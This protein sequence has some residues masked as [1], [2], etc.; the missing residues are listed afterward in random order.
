VA[1][2]TSTKLVIFPKESAIVVVA[3]VP[4]ADVDK[5]AAC[6]PPLV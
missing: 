1:S 5:E 2:L 6:Y 4:V 3:G